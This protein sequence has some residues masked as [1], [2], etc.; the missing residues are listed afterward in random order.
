MPQEIERKFL[1]KE[2]A[3]VAYSKPA[4]IVIQQGYIFADDTKSVRIRTKGDNAFLTIKQ[5]VSEIIREEFEYSIPVEDAIYMLHKMANAV[6]SKWRYEIQY[7]GQ[8]WEVDVFHGDNEGLIVAEIELKSQDE[9]FDM[10]EW[11]S[12]EV[13]SDPRYLN[14]HLAKRPFKTWAK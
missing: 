12:E 1:V 14:V 9:T 8:L 4:P 7:S 11:V 5:S 10:P 3:W 2:D 13:S 6:I